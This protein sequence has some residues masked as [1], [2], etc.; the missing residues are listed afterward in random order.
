MEVRSSSRKI[1][2]K[3]SICK[4][5]N[6]KDLGKLHHFLGMKIVQDDV[7]GDIWI[8]QPAYIVKVV[9]KYGMK[10]AKCVNTPVDAGSRLVKAI[11]GDELFDQVVYQ[12]TIGSLLYLSTGTRPDIAFAVSNAARFSSNPSKQHWIAVK[13]IIRYLKGTRDL[14]YYIR[15]VPRTT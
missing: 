2:F 1:F 7:S 4:R 14:E 3:S 15:G 13:R 10:D 6:V 5:F 8:G 12:S 11:E 9:E